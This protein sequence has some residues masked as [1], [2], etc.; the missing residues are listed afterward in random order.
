[1]HGRNLRRC[2]VVISTTAS[3]QRKAETELACPLDELH[4]ASHR[5][6]LGKWLAEYGELR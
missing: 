1:M 6:Q 3:H 2:R 4:E 5:L